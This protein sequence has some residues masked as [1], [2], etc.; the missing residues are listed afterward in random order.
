M[1]K[2]DLIK[3]YK[4]EA[5]KGNPI[6]L[7]NLGVFYLNGKGVEQNYGK[8]IK[9]FEEA[10]KKGS[11]EA[12]YNLGV[13]YCKS[14]G[15]DQPDYE[16]AFTYL[17]EA[18]E[19]GIAAALDGL[20]RMYLYGYGMY[21]PDY[22]KAF[23]YFN[24]AVENGFAQSLNTIGLM[25]KEGV[26]VDRDYQKA[27]EYFEIAAK[28]GVV[29]A[30]NNLAVMYKEGKGVIQNYEIAKKYF[31]EAAEKGVIDALN[32]LAFLYKEG[33]GV[34]QNYEKAIDYYKECIKLAKNKKLLSWVYSGVARCYI[35]L[36]YEALA[37]MGDKKRNKKNILAQQKYK[38]EA[39]Q[40][41]KLAENF[42]SLTNN[43]D[44][45]L[46]YKE[47][48][49]D[50]KKEIQI[51]KVILEEDNA[52]LHNLSYQEFRE[53]FFN[54]HPNI[55][56]LSTKDEFELYEDGIKRYFKK[57]DELQTKIE[58]KIKQEQERFK[59][60]LPIIKKKLEE[61][62]IA[63]IDEE[64]Q[65][66]YE[67][68]VEKVK[69][70]TIIDFSDCVVGIDKYIE[71]T[72]KVIFKDGLDIYQEDIK[73]QNEEKFK[74]DLGNILSN[75]IKL[76][77]EFVIN[78]FAAF[79]GAK[80]ISNKSKEYCLNE[81]KK[82][83]SKKPDTYEAKINNI[84]EFLNNRQNLK[85]DEISFINKILEIS[86]IRKTVEISKSEKDKSISEDEEDHFTLGKLFFHTFAEQAISIDGQ[87]SKM[88]VLDENIVNYVQ[89]INPDKDKDVIELK[90]KELI[91]KIE[92]FRVIVRNVASHTTELGQKSIEDGLKICI[93][94]D[95]SIFALMDE[96]FG[97]Y[98]L[99]KYIEKQYI[100]LEN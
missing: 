89:S 70:E 34:E 93:M 92:L 79:Q 48:I 46:Y 20:G 63:N 12:K 94:Q 28:N 14:I 81:I 22:R 2:T 49:E 99:Q 57:R 69:D 88:R 53:K 50:C 91:N 4:K 85:E 45:V 33:C 29:V 76:E 16:K 61:L 64:I 97:E 82:F 9:L 7:Y 11:Q 26:F 71:E 86:E 17:K 90:I 60:H 37:N 43:K 32:N 36:Y 55:F 39:K 52:E 78:L 84:K 58:R 19:N 77:D 8:A 83:I 98:I 41:L 15:L 68:I 100:Q 18:A 95:N 75:G 23:Y 1:V 51:Y 87:T 96:L 72:I 31:E 44:D 25:Y 80:N 59:K 5:M 73:K 56:L 10:A 62:K 65:I 42:L 13:I 24:Q 47:E 66:R 38:D 35:E 30:L 40:Y 6:A 54:K 67:S 3:F 74:I 27:F 21:Q